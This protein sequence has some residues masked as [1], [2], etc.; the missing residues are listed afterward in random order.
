MR[1]KSVITAVL[2][3]SF[4]AA[5]FA[6]VEP[7]ASSD[8]VP[9]ALKMAVSGGLKVEKSFQ[10]ASGLK[11]WVL[12]QGPANNMIVYTTADGET[13]IAG[14]MV[15]STGENLTKKY[16]DQYAPKPNYEKAWAEVEKSSWV[17]EGAKGSAVKSVVYVFK[18]AN[19]GYCH[20]AWKAL[21]AYEVA[22][23]QV[24]WVPV[25]FL[26][27]DSVTKAAALLDAKDGAAALESLHTNFGKKNVATVQPS[28]AA[29]AK[30]E[31]NTQLM[32]KLGFQ[33]TPVT[34]YKDKAGKVN[35]VQGMF[36]LSDLPGITNL[37][38]QAN[39]DP[40]LAK[41]Q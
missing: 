30:V 17:A 27:P 10:A 12:S 8:S 37:P 18:D 2:S 5:A 14:S 40:A 11:G 15:S 24:R 38:A 35:A 26:A 3:F 22:G 33:G 20:L 6:G 32:G 23:L 31:A 34:L 36:K 7:A 9:P 28:T 25:A 13:A 1:I 19:C 21:Q 16:L 4:A 41:F 39:T 29:K